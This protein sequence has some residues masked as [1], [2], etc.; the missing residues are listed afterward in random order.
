MQHL[1]YTTDTS[2]GFPLCFL[3]PVIRKDEIQKEYLTPFGIP[4][5]EVLVLGLHYS[6]DK[7][8]TSAAE[9]KEYITSE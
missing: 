9:R 4:V 2:Q 8:K 7:K 6:Q 3:V 5:E 1:T